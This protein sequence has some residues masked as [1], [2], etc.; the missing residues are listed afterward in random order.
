LLLRLYDR[1]F[2]ARMLEIP[3]HDHVLRQIPEASA[4]SPDELHEEGTER[5]ANPYAHYI[6]YHRLRSTGWLPDVARRPR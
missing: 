2:A 4:L 3:T 1:V 5:D 6:A